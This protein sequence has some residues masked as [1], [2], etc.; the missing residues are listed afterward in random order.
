MSDLSGVTIDGERLDEPY[1][2]GATTVGDATP[3][4]RVPEGHYFLM[5]DNRAQSC[6]SRIYGPVAETNLVARIFARF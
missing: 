2:E 1:V 3:A 5:G 6:D 4:V